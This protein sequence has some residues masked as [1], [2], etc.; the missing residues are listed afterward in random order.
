[1]NLRQLPQGYRPTQAVIS[2]AAIKSNLALAAKI[3]G[4]K[5]MA[6]V[7]AD[8]YGMRVHQVIPAIHK[9]EECKSFA[10]AFAEEAVELRELLEQLGN[11][12]DVIALEG[13]FSEADLELHRKHNLVAVI[14]DQEQIE[15]L[16]QEKSGG[17]EPLSIWLKCSSGMN[18]L[19]LSP[20]EALAAF[21]WVQEQPHINLLGIMTHFAA[22]NREDRSVSL[23]QIRHFRETLEPIWNRLAG[24]TNSAGTGNNLPMLSLCNSPGIVAGFSQDPFALVTPQATSLGADMNPQPEFISRPGLMLYGGSP[25]DVDSAE[26]VGIKPV[27]ELKSKLMAVR[28]LEK[29]DAVGYEGA[30]QAPAPGLMGVVPIGYADGYPF[31]ET[32]KISQIP[33][34]VNGRKCFL[35]GRVSM[36][37]L[38]VDLH[39]CPDAKVGDEVELWGNKLPIHEI[40]NVIGCPVQRLFSALTKRV[41]RIH[42]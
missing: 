6:V 21:I 1:M 14:H 35:G 9:M 29:G 41:P 31:V 15:M 5:V 30:W 17:G 28:H 37:M 4:S 38:C 11:K 26:D 7:K 39:N 3:S 24:D 20:Q 13:F 8:A 12:K 22:A 32:S 34:L 36:D 10:V 2:L 23:E 25:M 19:G 42:V 40:A 18:R 27:M 33:L 16:K